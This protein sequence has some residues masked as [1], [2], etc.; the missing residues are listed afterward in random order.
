[1]AGVLSI[2]WS[3]VN[4]LEYCKL[5]GYSGTSQRVTS[6]PSLLLRL[7]VCGCVGGWGGGG[8]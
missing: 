5:S 3:T 4:W 7:Q 6:L 1:V 8:V 2:G